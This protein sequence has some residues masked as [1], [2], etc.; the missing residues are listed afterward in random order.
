LS[1]DDSVYLPISTYQKYLDKQDLSVRISA[2]VKDVDFVVDAV[3]DITDR[4]YEEYDI[5]SSEN[6][7]RVID[8]GSSV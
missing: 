1:F 3:Q 5:D 6:S 8:A 2:L 7:I 4:I